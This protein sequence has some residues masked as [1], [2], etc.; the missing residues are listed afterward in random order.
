V[1]ENADVDLETYNPLDP[2]VQQNPFPS[3]ATLRRKAPVF[4]HPLTG[5]YFVSRYSTVKHVLGDTGTFSSRMANAVSASRTNF[6]PE[7]IEELEKLRSLTSPPSNTMLT[8]DPPQQTRYRKAMGRDFNQRVPTFEPA[9]RK[10]ARDLIEPWPR[11]GRVDFMN[12]FAVPFPVRTIA[13]ALT[14]KAG[15]ES[16]IKRWSDDSV[17]ALGVSIDGERL[18]ESARGVLELQRYW[19]DRVETCRENP[20]DDFLSDLVRAQFEEADGTKRLLNTE[21]C[22]SI[23]Q[24]LM[25]AG[26]ET[27][28]K[29]LNEIMKLLAQNPDQW[30][31]LREE[32]ARVEAVVEEGLRI[33]S[34]NQGLFRQVRSDTELEG[35]ELP[36][37]STMWVMF[38]SAN[39][40]A[41]IFPDP[42]RF[43]PD[44]PNLR[45]HLAFGYAAHFC[46]GAPLA[47]LETKI[48]LEE[49]LARVASFRIADD[50][51]LTYEP[52]FILRGL[53]ELDLEIERR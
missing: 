13:A 19:I 23:L 39:R 47:R 53:A 18:L 9:I 27:T 24:Q 5:I 49:I 22:I 51:K 11:S 40:D 25:V 20:G 33:A 43:D 28:T 8:A 12:S 32:P 46:I 10:I 30:Q 26:N 36:K 3:Y 21:E 44:R 50:C 14:M 48:A 45:E 2:A 37:G 42:D 35:V 41:E 17:A 6:S 31:R 4:R 29:L 15:L 52:S 34:P 1:P 7:I 38:G 16:D